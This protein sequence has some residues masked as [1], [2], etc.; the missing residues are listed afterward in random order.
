MGQP[1]IE[2]GFSVLETDV[3]AITTTVP[4]RVYFVKH[5]VIFHQPMSHAEPDINKIIS[6]IAPTAMIANI[7]Q[8]SS[9]KE[10]I[11]II[12]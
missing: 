9:I 8:L 10:S 3:L 7:F 4:N 6:T 1:G 11:A 12:F 2:P 5:E